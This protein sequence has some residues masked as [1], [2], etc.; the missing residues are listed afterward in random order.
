[1][2][3]QSVTGDITDV[4]TGDLRVWERNPRRIE[5]DRFESLKRSMTEDPDMLRARPLIA[6]PDGRVIAGNMRLRAAQELGWASLPVV[7]VDMEEDRAATWAIRDNVGYG[8]WDDQGLADLLRDL[9]SSQVDLD[10]TGLVSEDIVSLLA[11]FADANAPPAEEER[12]VDLALADVSVGD[13]IHIVE[14]GD[15]W[16]LGDHFLVCVGLYEGWTTYMP[17]L[18]PGML[19]VPYPTPSLPLTER[20][21]LNQLVLVQPDRWLAGH[22]LDKWSAVRGEDTVSKL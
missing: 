11:E 4:S 6:L 5:Q 2:A 19:F 12:G 22:V 16:K 10:L 20:A 18:K 17:L 9:E 8:E 3:A 7:Y 1:M 13:P 15:V 21:T 14:T